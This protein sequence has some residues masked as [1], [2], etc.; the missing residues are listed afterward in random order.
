MGNQAAHRSKDQIHLSDTFLALQTPELRGN[1][2][3]IAFSSTLQN[4]LGTFAIMLIPK[5]RLP[6]PTGV[7]CLSKGTEFGRKPIRAPS[8]KKKILKQ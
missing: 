3:T 6:Y 4:P 2:F 5:H 1:C 8:K 7:P